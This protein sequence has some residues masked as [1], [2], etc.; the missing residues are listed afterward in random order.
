MMR[1]H[2]QRRERGSDEEEEEKLNRRKLALERSPM[3]VVLFDASAVNGTLI[4]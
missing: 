1:Q 2:N 3:K 4:R